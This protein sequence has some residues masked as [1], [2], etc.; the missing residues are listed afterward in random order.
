MGDQSALWP[1][2]PSV[3]A[4]GVSDSRSSVNRARSNAERQRPV[5]TL[6]REAATHKRP[7]KIGSARVCL[8]A[9]ITDRL[10]AIA[11]RYLV[12]QHGVAMR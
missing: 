11:R 2:R 1:L 9:A 6:P 3:L 8:A 4:R 10:A 5:L 7:R 12:A